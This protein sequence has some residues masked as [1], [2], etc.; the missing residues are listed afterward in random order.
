MHSAD[1]LNL[2]AAMF[3]YVENPSDS[4][5]QQEVI[6]QVDE[7]LAGLTEYEASIESTSRIIQ[8]LPLPAMAVINGHT[9]TGTVSTGNT[10]QLTLTLQNNGSATAHQVRIEL[11]PIA[12]L[13]IHAPSSISIDGLASAEQRSINAS[14]L[15]ESGDNTPTLNAHVYTDE[16]PTAIYTIVL[17]R[18]E[19]GI[20]PPPLLPTPDHDNRGGVGGG[21][22]I[23]FVLMALCIGGVWIYVTNQR[24]RPVSVGGSLKRPSRAGSSGQAALR[25]LHGSSAGQII[26]LS[27][28]SLL[29]GR[30]RLCNIILDDLTVSRQHARLQFMNGYWYLQDQ[31]SKTGVYVNG[32]R[33]S[34][35]TL[36]SG[37]QIRI[38]GTIF[39]FQLT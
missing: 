10:V 5:A 34:S 31:N 26:P 7:V 15:I 28:P 38:G 14:V 24:R 17:Q 27:Q 25:I 16:N 6:A 19:G 36:H 29:I 37:D 12:G 13:Q 11:Q 8:T 2:Y 1:V 23:A 32:Q 20:I 3:K 39:E 9:A 21:L 30:S 35:V 22:G 4:V 33:I 18:E